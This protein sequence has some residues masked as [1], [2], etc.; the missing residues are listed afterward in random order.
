MNYLLILTLLLLANCGSKNGTGTEEPKPNTPVVW[1]FSPE[2][3]ADFSADGGSQMITITTNAEWKVTSDQTWC[4]T[5]ATGG[6]PTGSFFNK[7]KKK[8]RIG[9]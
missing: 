3:L 6:F 8:N 2:T 5:S 7:K 1:T 4:T 9:N